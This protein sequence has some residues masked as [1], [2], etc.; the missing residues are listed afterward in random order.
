MRRKLYSF[1]RGKRLRDSYRQKSYVVRVFHPRGQYPRTRILQRDGIFWAD[2][3]IVFSVTNSVPWSVHD[4]DAPYTEMDWLSLDELRF[5]GSIFLTERR[6]G[7]KIGFYPVYRYGPRIA[8]K[9]LDLAKSS[10]ADQIRESVWTQIRQ[11]TPGV[12]NELKECC[13]LRYSLVDPIHFNLDRQ[14]LYFAGISTSDYVMLRGISAL[15]KSDMLSSYYEFFEEATVSA[16]IAMEASFR[17]IVRKLESEGM[18]NPTAREAAQWVFEHFDRPMGMPQQGV[19]RY[20]EE[21]YD[22]R[23][24]TLHPA[25]RFGDSPYAPVSADDYYHLRKALREILAYLAAAS[26]G[27][28]FYE[29]VN[30]LAASKRVAQARRNPARDAEQS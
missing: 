29:E 19:E 30:S 24:M 14:P 7:A 16:F 23:V 21:F 26:H 4:K 1:L 22:Q 20:F 9:D 5:L 28:D 13:T 18:A 27:P 10:V 15:I 25:S 3:E 11:P 12:R 2:D 17:L 6:H 8:R